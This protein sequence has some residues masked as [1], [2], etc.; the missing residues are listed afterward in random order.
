MPTLASETRAMTDEQ[1]LMRLAIRAL[2]TPLD[3]LNS[4][5]AAKNIIDF[6]AARARLRPP[7]G[8]AA[9]LKTID[10]ALRRG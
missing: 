7:T 8:L 5:P 10:D 2:E 1:F 6:D 9:T 4:E 3:Q